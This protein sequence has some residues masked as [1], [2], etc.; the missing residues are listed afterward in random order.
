MG[1]LANRIRRF[2]RGEPL[3]PKGLW[4]VIVTGVLLLFTAIYTS[5][6]PGGSLFGALITIATG[7]GITLVGVA[8]YLAQCMTEQR[9]PIVVFL[10]AFAFL[11]VSTVLL[12]FV[13]R[14]TS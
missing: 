10:R 12:I 7:L 3:R 6:R 9:R 8:E 14:L 11:L 2:S 13:I 5:T 1:D 4:I